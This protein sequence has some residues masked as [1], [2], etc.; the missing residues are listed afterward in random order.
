MCDPLHPPESDRPKLWRFFP[1]VFLAVSLA[2]VSVLGQ[3]E[4]EVDGEE[5][6]ELNPFVVTERDDRGYVSTNSVSGAGINMAIRD[7]PVP[8]EVLNA[9]YIEDLQATDLDETLQYSAGVYT[10][11]FESSASSGVNPFNDRS[12]SAGGNVNDDNANV[13]SIRGY[14]VPNQQRMGFRV[15]GN[16]PS[17]GVVLGG[18]TDTITTA[19]TEVV[20]GPQALLYGI[21]VLS[22]IVNM[23]AKRPLEQHHLSSSLSMGN[24]GYWRATLDA[25]GPATDFLRVR[26]LAAYQEDGDEIDYRSDRRLTVALQLDLD[27]TDRA[28]LFIEYVH[29]DQRREGIGPQ[30]FSLNDSW[31]AD[32]T[33]FSWTNE[34]GETMTFGRDDPT[35][36]FNDYLGTVYSDPVIR[37]DGRTYEF[38]DLGPYY[39]VSGP[40][41][42]LERKENNL[43]ALL[44]VSILDSLD[45]ELGA[46]YTRLEDEVFSVDLNVSQGNR[47]KL[48]WNDRK[49]LENN[50]EYD[51][52]DLIGA[53]F[54]EGLL[55]PVRQKVLNAP[56]GD[57][58]NFHEPGWDD[59][60]DRIW[61]SY[62]WYRRPVTAETLQ[63]RGRLA[64]EAET[65]WGGVPANHTLMLG[66]H[67]IQDE[68]EFVSGS[69]SGFSGQVRSYSNVYTPSGSDDTEPTEHGDPFNLRSSVFDYTPLRYNGEA[70]ATLGNVTTGN[71]GV[72][73]STLDVARS[74][75]KKAHLT[76]RGAYGVYVGQFWKDRLTLIAGAR[77]D[78]YQVKEMEQLIPLNRERTETT[79]RVEIVNGIPQVIV[80]T[81]SYYLSDE[82]LGHD[83]VPVAIG[84]GNEEWVA[85][86]DFSDELNDKIG[87]S[88]S[89][90]R[91]VLP[92]GTVEFNYPDGA[93]TFDTAT[94]GF[95]YR[96]I[97]PLSAYFLHSEG[98][99]PNT[100]QRDGANK[101]IDA[102]Q[103]VNN[104]I[105]LKFDLLDGRLSGTLS[106]YQIERKNAVY[107]FEAAPAPAKWH[108]GEL[109]PMNTND[110]RAF[111]A[112]A[113]AGA[114]S[115][116]FNGAYYPV[117]MGVALPYVIK[118]FEEAGIAL[119]GNLFASNAFEPWGGET[120]FGKDVFNADGPRGEV[121]VYAY[122]DTLLNDPDA[123][124]LKNA[125]DMAM[126]RV[127]VPNEVNGE[128]GPYN[129]DPISWYP[130][131]GIV[132]NPSEGR[133]ANVTFEEKGIGMDGQIIAKP[134]RDRDFQL[135]FT[136]SHQN[137]E[138]AGNG[139]T[140][141][142][143]IDPITGEN[144]GTQY[145]IW[146][147]YLGRENFA[148]PTRASTYNG[149]SVKG[150]DLSF[151]PKT[152][153][154]LWAKYGFQEWVP[155][156]E[157]GG[158][159]SYNGSV[160]TS[161]AV[162]GADLA[163]NRY[164]TPDLPSRYQAGM[165]V[166][167]SPKDEWFGAQW[168]FSLNVYNLFDDTEAV[169]TASYVND[170]GTEV[171]RRTRQYYQPRSFRIKVSASF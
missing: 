156:L 95:T 150:I 108:G 40:D 148:D 109:G 112:A 168:R 71:L 4:D 19:R 29:A 56:Y 126:D 105:G 67:F 97:E 64:Y 51:A 94:Y 170:Y 93:K 14:K 25:G 74:G 128:L 149:A 132:N 160:K 55:L 107:F 15:G 48:L 23:Q 63:L 68:I 139:F 169:A 142:D 158:G 85:R 47:G 72:A 89:R 121:H 38:P 130:L 157:L 80:E 62:A 33:G 151:V 140:L 58:V 111:S 99:F 131:E 81:N 66:Y 36:D 42:F 49:F 54:A 43:L 76:F 106:V 127:H 86:E 91:E 28:N 163:I 26:A 21:N 5:V 88:I 30:F 113:A 115:D 119:P 145:D 161:V 137:R 122:Y 116:Y 24:L 9:E 17:Y 20:R 59:K 35:V 100:G 22:G 11:S 136:F 110:S 78:S 146:V 13:I 83:R 69:V 154:R 60:F 155:G 77:H 65:D 141:V 82:R 57:K 31:P 152:S 147:Y 133:G 70:V 84:Y 52:S 98:I 37:K 104:E 120:K 129:G 103:T 27:L 134:F 138:V 144:W 18:S 123:E 117:M 34:W 16:V 118:A 3:N 135:I 162:G 75:W 1:C 167:Y 8:L 2:G 90:L 143:A 92:N 6:I 39:N 41:T 87:D 101:P 153:F 159:L 73:A 61:A 53:G 114:G 44:A 10:Q 45:L 7:I 166:G 125:F 164:P 79:A 46:Y 12:P 32:R 50:P 165:F 102:E 124:I 96:I 171:K